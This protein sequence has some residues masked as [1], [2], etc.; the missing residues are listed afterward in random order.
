VIATSGNKDTLYTTVKHIWDKDH[1]N[2]SVAYHK[3]PSA[4]LQSNHKRMSNV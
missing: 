2:S 3:K 1:G 4:T